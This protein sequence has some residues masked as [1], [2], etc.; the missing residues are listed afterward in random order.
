M[1]PS[2]YLR[3]CLDA[4]GCDC[5]CSGNAWRCDVGVDAC[6]DVLFASTCMRRCAHEY[7]RQPMAINSN[8]HAH[9]FC[10]AFCFECLTAHSG[11]VWMVPVRTAAMQLARP[12]APIA[13]YAAAPPSM[14][15]QVAGNRRTRYAIGHKRSTRNM[16]NTVVGSAEVAS[17]MCCKRVDRLACPHDDAI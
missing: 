4:E 3:S 12:G 15:M 1:L 6:V 7:A 9:A 10:Y 2:K 13:R 8:K 16:Q 11:A 14:Q 17:T 5:M